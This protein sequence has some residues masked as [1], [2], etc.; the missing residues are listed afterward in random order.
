MLLLLLVV[1]ASAV[2]LIDAASCGSSGIP[3]RLEVM[4]DGHPVLGCAS[5]ICF[6]TEA[7]GQ[8]VMH[9]SQFDVNAELVK[10]HFFKIN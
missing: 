7:G 4:P 5:P 8:R 10:H 9:D 1:V 6:G 3:F 2:H